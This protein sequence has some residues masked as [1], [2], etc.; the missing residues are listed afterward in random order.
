MFKQF[1]SQKFSNRH[2]RESSP[3]RFYLL[4]NNEKCE[5]VV[6]GR[7]NSEKQSELTTKIS[8]PKISTKLPTSATVTSQP[9]VPV[10]DYIKQ[11]DSS[12]VLQVEN[13]DLHIY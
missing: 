13:L 3:F 10:T 6:F 5:G 9:C 8:L 1:N 7:E 12:K 4:N 2:V 11:S